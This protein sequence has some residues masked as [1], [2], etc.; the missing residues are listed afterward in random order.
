MNV[1]VLPAVDDPLSV[2]D[3]SHRVARGERSLCGHGHIERVPAEPLHRD[4]TNVGF[5]SSAD[6]AC[7]IAGVSE[8]P[9]N[10]LCR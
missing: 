2:A 1:I 7:S 3:V 4:F 10:R 9:S 6:N 8:E 5:R